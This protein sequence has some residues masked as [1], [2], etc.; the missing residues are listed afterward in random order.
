MEQSDRVEKRVKEEAE[1]AVHRWSGVTGTTSQ[2]FQE[3]VRPLVER[4]V[5][6]ESINR[7]RE[8]AIRGTE[9]TRGEAWREIES[10]SEELT[11]TRDELTIERQARRT[12]ADL[13]SRQ[14]ERINALEVRAAE[15]EEQAR[16]TAQKLYEER[17]EVSNL[18]GML[19]TRDILLRAADLETEAQTA[20]GAKLADQLEAVSRELADERALKARYGVALEQAE[21]KRRAAEALVET[22]R[23]AMRGM[24]VE[25]ARD[26]VKDERRVC[27]VG[28]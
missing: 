2:A 14:T 23:G 13:A 25:W 10:L 7:A 24:A 26:I 12:A 15:A 28:S 8:D 3:A 21:T 17:S 5:E 6:L 1:K 18:R 20:Y 16:A 22:L 11:S 27:G 4:I 19:E 9:N